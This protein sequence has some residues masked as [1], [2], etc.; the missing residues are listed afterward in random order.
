MADD[1][2]NYL[3][4]SLLQ[5]RLSSILRAIVKDNDFLALKRRVPNGFDNLFDRIPFIVARDCDR[6]LIPGA[7]TDELYCVQVATLN[8]DVRPSRI[9]TRAGWATATIDNIGGYCG[10]SRSQF[11]NISDV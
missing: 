7:N 3:R 5:H 6:N 10:E 11:R 2:I 9:K 4:N 1:L 8:T